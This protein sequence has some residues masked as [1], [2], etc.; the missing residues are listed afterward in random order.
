M[1]NRP[2]VLLAVLVLGTLA[3]ACVPPTHPGPSPSPAEPGYTS[4]IYADPA[5]WICRP[6]NADDLCHGDLAATVVAADGTHRVEHLRPT[7]LPL[8]DCFYVY[9]T[10]SND[11]GL[12]SD[13]DWALDQ[14]GQAVRMQASRF[15]STCRV[16]APAYR[17]VTITALND[18]RAIADPTSREVPYADV[19]DAWHHYLAHD[20]HG[21]P[22]ILIGHS[23][24]AEMLA[25]L[26]R[27][28]IEPDARLRSQLVAADLI[29]FTIQVAR[30]SDTG[31][32]FTT[33][34][35]TRFGQTGC[36]VTFGSYRTTIPPGQAGLF[37]AAFGPWDDVDPNWPA[38]GRVA[39]CTNPAALADPTAAPDAKSWLTPYFDTVAQLPPA[40]AWL[41]PTLG[42]P[43]TPQVKL[44]R[45]VEAQCV[46]RGIYTYLEITVHGDPADPRTDDIAGDTEVP[47]LVTKEV[48]GL[49]VVDVNLTSGDLVRLAA[50]QSFVHRF[51]R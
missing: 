14:E 24:G 12:H 34:A 44:P 1:R 33:P 42:T 51:L 8:A 6:D 25:R 46:T 49:H 7:P 11:P 32:N 30:G 36:I 39:S 16:F 22:F 4:P 38:D 20:N 21:R 47:G 45:F 9:P 27:Q 18:G 35:C 29:G 31:G 40:G 28:E 10:A 13:L 48:F 41:D 43:T 2:L 17:S 15:A 5:N 23:Q 26:L 37:G 50:I 19:L 3:T